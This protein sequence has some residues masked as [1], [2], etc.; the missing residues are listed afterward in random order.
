MQMCSE[1]GATTR[2]R[3]ML[4]GAGGHASDVLGAI[5]RINLG[6]PV[7]DVIGIADDSKVPKLERFVTRNIPFLGTIEEA[8]SRHPD[9]EFLAT[10]GFPAGRRLVAERAEHAG[11]R[12]ATLVDPRAIV[13]PSVEIGAGSVIM[14][15]SYLSAL[16]GIGRHVYVSGLVVVGHDTTVGDYSS[17]MPGAMICG[18][19]MLGS[20]VLVGANATVL[21]GARIEE[22]AN[23]GAGAVVRR[24]AAGTTVSTIWARRRLRAA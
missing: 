12:A 17:L 19:A 11:C 14:G 21:Q 7:W 23:V 15:G 9:V 1:A 10:V 13:A 16:V 24:V 8:L 5:E 3:V 6:A 22:G 20:D 4:L 2:R 18:D